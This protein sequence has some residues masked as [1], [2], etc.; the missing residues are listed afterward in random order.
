[1][2]TSLGVAAPYF[3]TGLS[4]AAAVAVPSLCA[5]AP[6]VVSSLGVS[7]LGVAFLFPFVIASLG[8]ASFF[9]VLPSTG[10]RLLHV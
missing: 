2:I 5:A 4:V 10:A 1:M 3:S 7:P 6:V 8:V 9:L